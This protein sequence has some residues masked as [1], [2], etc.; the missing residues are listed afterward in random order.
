MNKMKPNCNNACSGKYKDWLEVNLLRECNGKCS[1]CIEKKGWHPT[2]YVS[3][4]EI[5]DAAVKS[6]AKNVILLGGEPTLHENIREIVS[7]LV[8]NG[9]KVWITTNGSMLNETFVREFINGVVGV[10]VS[11]H[12][13]NIVSN[14]RITGI[15][16]R[17][18]KLKDA[19]KQL[20]KQ[21]ATV[22]FNCNCIRGEVDNKTEIYKYI[23]FAMEYGAD[24]VRF[25][26]LKEEEEN[27]VNLVEVMGCGHGLSNDPFKDGCSINTVMLGMPVNFRLMCGLQTT[28][29]PMPENP[30]QVP[31]N[32]LYYDG[33]MYQGWQI[34]GEMRRETRKEIDMSVAKPLKNDDELIELLMDIKKG[35]VSILEAVNRIKATQNIAIMAEANK[36]TGS[37]HCHY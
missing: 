19:I 21:R 24:S 10:N 7:S 25:A 23:L 27:F 11:I 6:G 13:H 2:Q 1:W 35:K 26:E 18:S 12:S 9:I 34:R 15:T 3:W 29:R 16:L 31:H 20:H 14:G 22:R 36:P 8:G 4:M 33:K 30:E 17:P 5:V 28:K 37:D 32:V